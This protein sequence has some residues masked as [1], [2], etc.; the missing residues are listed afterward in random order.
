MGQALRDG[1]RFD[2]GPTPEGAE[3]LARF[4]I[5]PRR[6]VATAVFEIPR[7]A[8]NQQVE[9]KVAVHGGDVDAQLQLGS[10]QTLSASYIYVPAGY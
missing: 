9:A 5:S 3:L 4:D 8:T 7:R 2:I 6:A 10:G 1:E